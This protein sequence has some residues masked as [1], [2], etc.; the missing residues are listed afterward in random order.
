[1][2]KTF[3]SVSPLRS[4]DSNFA[5]FVKNASSDSLL[6]RSASVT[7]SGRHTVFSAV[8]CSM[9]LRLV[10]FSELGFVIVIPVLGLVVY[11]KFAGNVSILFIN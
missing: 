2:S 4:N 9:P 6:L 10:M 11:E 7:P 5:P 8:K 1:M 3:S